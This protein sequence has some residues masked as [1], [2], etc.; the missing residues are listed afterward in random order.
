MT[1]DVQ[2]DV[3]TTAPTEVTTEDLKRRERVV[4]YCRV[5]TDDSG[6]TNKTQEFECR[7]YC[8]SMGFEVMEVYRDEE[9]GTSPY[10]ED[11]GKMML[12]VQ[13]QQDVDYIVAYD[14]SRITRGDD[15]KKLKALIEPHRCAFKFVKLDID[16]STIG[17]RI[18]QAVQTEI[19]AEENRVRNEKTRL[20]MQE[21][22]REGK[23]VGRP[24]RIMFAEDKPT[25]L[26][27]RYKEGFTVMVNEDQIYGYAKKGYSLYFVAKEILEIPYNC[28]I[29]EMHQKKDG[30]RYTGPKD[31][32][33][34]YMTLCASAKDVRKGSDAQRVGNEPKTDAQR[35]VFE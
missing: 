3:P 13:L 24:A 1:S 7:K 30:T 6:Q 2:P 32:F 10:R 33:S 31:R 8:E 11:F 9:T 15:I 22:V 27:G 26:Q 25:A 34:E 16:D 17:G 5:S 35:V 28:L 18:T 23:H 29:N 21:R 19:N 4:I 12:R 14:Q 20:G